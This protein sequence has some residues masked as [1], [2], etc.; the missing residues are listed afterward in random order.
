LQASEL[1]LE[2]SP[3]VAELNRLL[4]RLNQAFAAQR[5]FVADAAHEL[6]S[7]LTSLRLQLQLLERATG[8]E[9]A[10]EARGML[11][12]GVE[13]AI[14][15]VEQL[16]TLARADPQ[17]GS[18]EFSPLDL[19]A[20]ARDALADC[21]GLAL[22]RHIDLG[23]DAPAPVTVKGDREAL[24]VLI[25]NLV[26][27]AVR[28]T[29]VGGAVH[30]SVRPAGGGALLEVSDTGPGIAV[31]ERGRVFD[32]FYRLPSAQERGTGLG[33]AIVRA[34]ATRH[35]AEVSLDDAPSG[36]LTARVRFSG[37]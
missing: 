36:G 23:L 19:T 24:R 13:R 22:E 9:A 28:Y 20:C 11:E 26:D 32:R 25:R 10:G 37:S 4:E 17:V 29:P 5:D 31:A 2:I 18:T 12:Q 33:L 35:A 15:L 27:N 1:P 21:H 34:I 3:L 6:R 14:H 8:P 16:L 30:V 7:P